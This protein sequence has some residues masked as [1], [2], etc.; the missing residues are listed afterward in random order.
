LSSGERKGS[1]G[2]IGR[3]TAIKIYISTDFAGAAGVTTL[4]HTFA[5]RGAEFER[6]RAFWVDDINAMMGRCAGGWGGR[7]PGQRPQ[8]RAS[9]SAGFGRRLC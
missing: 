6:S 4:K 3:E 2:L 8:D 5:A 1:I 9:I 7:S